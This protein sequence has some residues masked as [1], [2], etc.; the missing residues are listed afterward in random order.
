MNIPDYHCLTSNY[1]RGPPMTA[2][3]RL[4]EMLSSLSH[5]NLEGKVI[6]KTAHASG[7]GGSCD[8]YSA[9]SVKH[10]KKIAVKQI[11]AFMTK[12]K[13]F[14][15][16]RFCNHPFNPCLTIIF[17]ATREGDS[18]LDST[19]SRKCTAAPC[20]HRGGCPYGAEF[21]FRVDGKR[22]DA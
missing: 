5:L 7:F 20:L 12:D 13:N 3:D 8:V 16:V 18:Y 19:R 9:W 10:D 11:R 4:E 14:A 17:T 2:R 15:K 22:Y 21:A 6:N 1:I